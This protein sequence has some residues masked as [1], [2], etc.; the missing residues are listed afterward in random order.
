MRTAL[1]LLVVAALLLSPSLVLSTLISHSSPQNLTWGSQFADQIRGG[2]L[3]PRWLPDSFDGLGGPAFY[4]YA[5]VSFWVDALL[6]LVAPAGR[7]TFQLRRAVL[8]E[9]QWGW[10]LSGLSL[11][12]L[13][14]WSGFE[15]RIKR[16]DPANLHS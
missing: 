2:V 15:W 14:V 16:H 11:V 4:F 3:Y 12:L 9:E 7:H 13:L 5:P 6:S 1:I 8:P 10:A